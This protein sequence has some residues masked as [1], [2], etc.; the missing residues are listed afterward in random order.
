MRFI[1]KIVKPV[2]FMKIRMLALKP[3][4]GKVIPA[5]V[6]EK[7]AGAR[8]PVWAMAPADIVHVLHVVIKH[9]TS[10][11]FLAMSRS[12]QNVA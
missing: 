12:A 9:L 3:I 5:A 1:G 2:K 7:E 11:A 8:V 10:P 4:T 6:W